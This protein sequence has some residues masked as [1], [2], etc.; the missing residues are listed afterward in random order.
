MKALKS[1]NTR[2]TFL[3]IINIYHDGEDKCIN[4]FV[5]AKWPEGF[6]CECGCHEYYMFNNIKNI[7]YVSAIANSSIFKRRGFLVHQKYDSQLSRLLDPI[8]FSTSKRPS[9]PAPR[10]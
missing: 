2:E 1:R 3:N 4:F 9:Q 8:I 7:L 5:K 10:Q 6:E